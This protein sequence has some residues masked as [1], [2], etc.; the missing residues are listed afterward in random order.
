MELDS[1]LAEF[2]VDYSMKL[3]A[4]FADAR[5]ERGVYNSFLLKNGVA[6]VSS[7]EEVSGIGVRVLVR[8]TLGFAATNVLGRQ[9]VREAVKSAV[10][11]AGRCS[12]LRNG[13]RLSK[14]RAVR[15]RYEVRERKPLADVG[16]EDKL[17]ALVDVERSVV[18][19]NAGVV[20]RFFSL[21]DNVDE[22]LYVNSEGSSVHSRVPRVNFY[23]YMTL[24]RKGLSMQRY[25]QH[26]KAAG[27]EA[28]DEF[29]LPEVLSGEAVA[30]RQNM[31]KGV[32]V[33]SG[34]LDVV[35]GPE[36]T[37]IIVHESGGHPYEADRILGREA[38][39]AGESFI[40]SG[41]LG[42]TLGSEA[43]S[44]VDD[45]S[46]PNS[47][48][49]YLFDDEGVKA[50]RKYLM[51]RGV[52]SGFLHS[53][54]SSAVMGM[55]V[56]GASRAKG[57]DREPIPRMSNTFIEPG[58]LSEEELLEGVKKGVYIRNF[59]EWN[60]DDRRVNQKYVGADAYVISNGR[61]GQ[62]VKS[63]V[64]EITTHALYRSIDAVADNV[65]Y[66]AGSCGKGEPMQALPVWFGGPSLRIRG[67]VLK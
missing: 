28:L 65:E 33:S 61:L 30:L 60:I 66:H 52:I 4:R 55:P 42:Y 39:Q 58:D 46:L 22:K 36:I 45:P 12:G 29:K 23:Y 44:I 7:F 63:P 3:G 15:S 67:V 43:V 57:Y 47:F 50:Q 48:G 35:V 16:P 31:E 20:A 27:F 19:A 54:E 53:R 8:S 41:S 34:K 18:A 37:G 13:V 59:T 9:G 56:N 49:F 11:D 2:A 6:Q 40:G 1:D 17:G 26:G 5:L 38:A 21:S 62:P 32:K 24:S 25:W 14:C 51:R 64:L 10:R